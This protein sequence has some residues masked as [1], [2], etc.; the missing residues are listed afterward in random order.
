M[1]RLAWRQETKSP[2][3]G[4]D[5]R[6]GQRHKDPLADPEGGQLEGTGTGYG[7]LEKLRED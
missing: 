4:T 2:C 7:Q 3:L 1:H 5:R 6:R